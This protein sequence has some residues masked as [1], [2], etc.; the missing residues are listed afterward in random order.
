MTKVSRWTCGCY[1]GYLND[2]AVRKVVEDGEA[3]EE[4]PELPCPEVCCQGMSVAYI[5][6]LYRPCYLEL[7]VC[8]LCLFKSVTKHSL[9]PRGVALESAT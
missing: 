2:C 3:G 4:G 7:C 6:L 8:D 1:D 9:D 5:L